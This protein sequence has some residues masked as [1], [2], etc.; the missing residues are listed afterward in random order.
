MRAS[1]SLG[2]KE[3]SVEITRVAWDPVKNSHNFTCVSD[4]GVPED[5]RGLGFRVCFERES[6]TSGPSYKTL[7]L[8]IE[9]Y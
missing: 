3:D 2:F 5:H 8:W 1:K 7:V 9:S 6:I 4:Q